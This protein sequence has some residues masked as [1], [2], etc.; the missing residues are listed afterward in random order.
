MYFAEGRVEVS[1]EGKYLSTLSG[2]KVLG[3]LA[4]LYNCQRTATITAVTDCK[5]WAIE[6]QCFQTIMMRTGLIR[7]TEYTDFL[8][9]YAHVTFTFFRF[10]KT[11][12]REWAGESGL[13]NCNWPFS[14]IFLLHYINNNSGCFEFHLSSSV[15][16]LL[17]KNWNFQTQPFK[18]RHKFEACNTQKHKRLSLTTILTFH[19]MQIRLKSF[20]REWFIIRRKKD[21]RHCLLS[22]HW[23]SLSYKSALSDRL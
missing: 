9:R 13:H 22:W 7:Q 12:P 6:R 20:F 4:I 18:S 5:L 10:Q 11:N 17:A 14:F 3:E 1:R 21:H 16:S 8:K 15:A 23:S 2:A 19:S